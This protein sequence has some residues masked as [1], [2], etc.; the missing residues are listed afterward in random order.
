[1]I[2]VMDPVVWADDPERQRWWASTLGIDVSE[3]YCDTADL[4]EQRREVLVDDDVFD[5]EAYA[6]TPHTS[7]AASV[8]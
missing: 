1:M 2:D 5:D 8:A 3:S 6:P 7:A 4:V